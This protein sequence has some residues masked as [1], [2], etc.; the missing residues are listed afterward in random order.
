MVKF[1]KCFGIKR[2]ATKSKRIVAAETPQ[3]AMQKD[4]GKECD[5]DCHGDGMRRSCSVYTTKSV[6][7]NTRDRRGYTQSKL[8]QGKLTVDATCTPFNPRLLMDLG[9][10]NETLEKLNEIIDCSMRVVDKQTS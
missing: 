9:L 6:E 7:R 3:T 2:R 10:L 5:E 8:D 1:L 4:K